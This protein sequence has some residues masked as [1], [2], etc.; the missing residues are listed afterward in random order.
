MPRRVSVDQDT[1]SFAHALTL[2]HSPACSQ[3]PHSLICSRTHRLTHTLTHTYLLTLTHSH[4]FAYSQIYSHTYSLTHSSTHSHTAHTPGSSSPPLGGYEDKVK[5][6]SQA[7]R[8]PPRLF[9]A[10][11]SH[12]AQPSCVHLQIQLCI[13]LLCLHKEPPSQKPRVPPS[14]NEKQPTGME[15]QPHS[16]YG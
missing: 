1:H 7:E 10:S 4:T 6:L 15:W 16:N 12:P 9:L 5:T 13:W 14:S 8:R 2:T 11:Q 3:T